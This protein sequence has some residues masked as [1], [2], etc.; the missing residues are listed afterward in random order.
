[1]RRL[2]ILFFL[3]FISGRGFAQPYNNL[4]LE[5]GGIRG[6][7]YTGAIKELEAHGITDSLHNIAGTSV[8]A[9]AAAL[10][11]VGYTADELKQLM[12][13]LKVQTFNDG[14][15][16]F[17]GGQRRTRK[18]FGWYRGDA[19]EEWVGQLVK[20]RTGS[21]HTTFTQLHVLALK[22]HRFKDLYVTATNLSQQRAETF[23]YLTYPD[24]EIKTAVR[25]SISVPLYFSAVFLDSNGHRLRKP[26]PQDR[27]GIFVDGGILANYPLGLFDTSATGNYKTNDRTLGLKLERPEQIGYFDAANR[28]I[29]PY[30]I[31]NFSG[32]IAAL[33]NLIIEKLNRDQAFRH[34]DY[35]TIYI[36]T[37]NM[38]PRVRHITT[39]QKELLYDN[40]RQAAQKFFTHGHSH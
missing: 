29:A 30:E 39:A 31:R 24:M 18:L 19:L 4:V 8:G 16:I 25:T 33:Y 27:Y 6:I 37:S 11:S 9:V 10:M 36:S 5:G 40:G 15:G 1:M 17:I 23:S 2:I 34:E 7:A 13:G 20:A 3:L 38:N 22:D 26:S 14:R 21:E 12:F 32:Y 28:D 35:R